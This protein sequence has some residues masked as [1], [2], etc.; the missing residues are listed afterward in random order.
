[1][2]EL[3]ISIIIPI[4]KGEMQ[5]QRLFRMFAESAEVV[6]NLKNVEI[7][8]VN[9]YEKADSG[10]GKHI[11][12]EIWDSINKDKYS[13]KY[14]DDGKHRGIHGARVR[15]LGE[16]KYKY[17]LFFDQD[18]YIEKSYFL[19]QFNSLGNNDFVVCNGYWH[20]KQLIYSSVEQQKRVLSKEYALKYLPR[21]ISPGQVI[22]KKDIIPDVWCDNVL[23][24]NGNDDNLL[25]L[26]L[27]MNGYKWAINGH[28]E[29][30]H[31]E[32]GLNASYNWEEMARSKEETL[33]VVRKESLITG[34]DFHIYSSTIKR[35][36]NKYY[37]YKQYDKLFV[38]LEDKE[39]VSYGK[40]HRYAIYGMG[41][42]GKRLWDYALENDYAIEYGIDRD[43]NTKEDGYPVIGLEDVRD[44]VDCIIVTPVFS[45]EE[46]KNKLSKC[47]NADIVRMD[48]W[49]KKCITC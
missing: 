16:A 24:Y 7:V 27:I 21:V 19:T 47:S 48:E 31:H 49:M 25:W 3:S 15:G 34:N 44:D 33:E 29:Y 14:I 22:V 11:V 17:V 37:L 1:M 18:D 41:I 2:D 43:E 9:D 45:Y 12:E 28:A 8:F 35:Y 4:Y 26:I 23:K 10:C 39:N 6:S 30:T 46:I 20:D 13:V 32:N 38:E 42:Y 36:V 5:M 40:D